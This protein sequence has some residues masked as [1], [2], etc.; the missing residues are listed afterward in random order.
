MIVTED[1]VRRVL[2][3]VDQILG[4]QIKVPGYTR[5][6]LADTI[7]HALGET[8]PEQCPDQRATC[9]S[10]C[11]Q[12]FEIG[13][14][15]RK[16]GTDN[17]KS[18]RRL[19][20]AQLGTL[21]FD[22]AQFATKLAQAC[23]SRLLPSVLVVLGT[24]LGLQ[25]NDDLFKLQ[26]K[27][28][29]LATKC[30]DFP[31]IKV[32]TDVSKVAGETAQLLAWQGTNST[33]NY[34]VASCAAQICDT[35]CSIEATARMADTIVCLKQGIELAGPLRGAGVV[36][37]SVLNN[38]MCR[39]SEVSQLSHMLVKSAS[40]AVCSTAAAIRYVELDDV[41]TGD[42][43]VDC[44][45]QVLNHFAEIVVQI[46]VEMNTPGAKFLYMVQ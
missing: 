35:A 14:A 22:D 26:S 37:P 12:N 32:L 1:V 6:V 9:V 46:F 8:D 18:L 44:A 15:W 11:V 7:R 33:V 16:V 38:L 24:R 40:M 36:H 2:A 17:T 19:M 21:G 39:E 27:F 29:N 45:E 23:M 4:W 13:S 25:G 10:P 20:I 34:Q 42:N 3:S 28:L 41:V 31:S 5:L 30:H 43:P